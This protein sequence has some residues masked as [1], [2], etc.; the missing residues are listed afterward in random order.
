MSISAYIELD[1]GDIMDEIKDT[2]IFQDIVRQVAVEA[3]KEYFKMHCHDIFDDF[4]ERING[5]RNT[6]R[7]MREEFEQ[8]TES[9]FGQLDA[10]LD[11]TSIDLETEIQRLNQRVDSLSKKGTGEGEYEFSGAGVGLVIRF[12]SE[13]DLEKFVKGQL[14]DVFQPVLPLQ[15]RSIDSS[16]PKELFVLNRGRDGR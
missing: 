9:L 2:D 5:T 7:V 8:K 3:A 6:Q 12:A 10:R 13:E 11:G 1:S 15:T 14:T 4:N 16:D